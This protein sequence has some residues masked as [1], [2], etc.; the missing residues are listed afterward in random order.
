MNQDEFYQSWLKI[1]KQARAMEWYINWP[2]SMT[3]DGWISNPH[4][5][6]LTAEYTEDDPMFSNGC[7]G[8]RSWKKLPLIV[9]K[10]HGSEL[11]PWA[12]ACLLVGGP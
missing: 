2:L 10:R 8:E 1:D 4:K 5:D 9:L 6:L 11:E 7:F 3:E 12:L